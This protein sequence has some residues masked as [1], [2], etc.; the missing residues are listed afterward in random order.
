MSSVD[1]F[2]IIFVICITAIAVGFAATGGLSIESD[3]QSKTDRSLVSTS[4]LELEMKVAQK[5]SD[6]IQKLSKEIEQKTDK[7]KELTKEAIGAKLPAKLV[8]IPQG[9]STPGCEKATLCYDPPN[10]T[11]FV[12]GEVIWRN[13]DLSPHTVTSGIVITGPD[14][15][16]NSG[17][18]TVGETFSHRF[19]K[20]GEFPYFC[21]IHP[22]AT[23]M[24]TV[25]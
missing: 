19:D 6:D 12:G 8:S 11:I 1:K 3:V 18:V 13:D 14:G 5:A 15:N 17:L 21:M 24:V 2:G 7:A 16:F 23:G 25:S 9:T 22:W 10:V 20:T 4:E